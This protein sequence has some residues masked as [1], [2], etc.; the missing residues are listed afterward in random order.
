MKLTRKDVI[1][2]GIKDWRQN[3]SKRLEKDLY[4]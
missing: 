1:G 4:D 2:N 3:Y